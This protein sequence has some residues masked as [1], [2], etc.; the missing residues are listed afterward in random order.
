MKNTM[1]LLRH[2]IRPL[3]LYL[4]L[5][6]GAEI[7]YSISRNPGSVCPSG[8]TFDSFRSGNS[9]S[10]PETPVRLELWMQTWSELLF[11]K[12]INM[13]YAFNTDQ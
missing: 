1:Q 9:H 5:M 11:P 7:T 13:G 3:I 10:T 6:R 2:C 12:V 8:P 4:I